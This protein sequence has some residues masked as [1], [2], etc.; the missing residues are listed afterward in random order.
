MTN[1]TY[2]LI[3]VGSILAS[4]TMEYII[5]YN[6]GK[7]N[8][9]VEERQRTIESLSARALDLRHPAIDNSEYGRLREGVYDEI[10]SELNRF[11]DSLRSIDSLTN[12]K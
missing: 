1:R 7:T 10:A 5:G 11:A 6:Q 9:R 8:G 3:M 12:K 4:I 2:A